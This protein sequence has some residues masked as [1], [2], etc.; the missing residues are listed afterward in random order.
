MEDKVKTREEEGVVVVV[1]ANLVFES[2]LAF[3]HQL[4]TRRTDP[5][6]GKGKGREGR[7]MKEGKEVDEGRKMKERRKED[8]GRKKGRMEERM[9]EGSKEGSMKKGRKEGRKEGKEGRK[10]DEQ[11]TKGGEK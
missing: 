9:D 1:V 2:G 3:A 10:D 4:E 6:P 7:T 8:K 11:I 5:R